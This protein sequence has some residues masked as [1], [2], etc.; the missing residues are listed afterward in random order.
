MSEI[1]QLVSQASH[2]KNTLLLWCPDAEVLK[3]TMTKNSK[4]QRHR[5]EAEEN[6]RNLFDCLSLEF[7]AFSSW[8]ARI[9]VRGVMLSY[10]TADNVKHAPQPPSLERPRMEL[11]LSVLRSAGASDSAPSSGVSAAAASSASSI[12]EEDCG[13]SE[14]GR[15]CVVHHHHRKHCSLHCSLSLSAPYSPLSP[16]T[17]TLLP[18]PSPY[19]PLSLSLILWPFS[20]SFTTRRS[21]AHSQRCT[22]RASGR[23]R[24]RGREGEEMTAQQHAAAGGEVVAAAA[25]FAAAA[26]EAME[27]Q[28]LCHAFFGRRAR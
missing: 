1:K 4:N 2:C 19:L 8:S 9:E 11:P 23:R 5:G 27:L 16:P 14:Q 21:L 7:P 12:S 28:P 25:P 3:S 24:E 20:H 10:N 6:H 26:S 15:L 22:D 13:V 18:P 17:M